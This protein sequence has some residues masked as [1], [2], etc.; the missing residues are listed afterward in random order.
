MVD[1]MAS[2]FSKALF[3]FAWSVQIFTGR[4]LGV[5]DQGPV[6]RDSSGVWKFFFCCLFNASVDDSLHPEVEKQSQFDY[7]GRMKICHHNAWSAQSAIF[8]AACKTNQG[9]AFKT[10]ETLDSGRQIAG[11]QLPKRSSPR[12]D[13]ILWRSEWNLNR[14]HGWARECEL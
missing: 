7:F 11:Q 6:Q 8:S 3:D 10:Y 9:Y 5:E 4:L 13:L 12:G 1:K 2:D 14:K